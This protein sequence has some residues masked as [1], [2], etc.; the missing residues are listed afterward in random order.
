MDGLHDLGG[1]EGFGPVVKK[2]QP[3]TDDWEIRVNALMGHLLKRHVFNMDEYRHAIERMEPRQYVGA[4]Y[5]E[6]VFTAVATLS[7]EKGLITREE[8]DA[9]LGE[10]VPL[11]RPSQSGRTCEGPLPELAI[12]DR[13]T[14]KP[15][16][17]PGH[18][19]LPAYIRGKTG[20][21][22]GVSPAYPFPDAA[23]HG[24]ESPRQRT[25]D[26]RF[27]SSDLWPGGCEEADV[28]VGVF[29]A[30]LSKCE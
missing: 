13:V 4:S 7:V 10:R 18:I 24:L 27:R 6:R 30:Y 22:V 1:R 3:F 21:V 28:H 9:A 12:G 5:F 25:F 26:V 23:A 29:H 8:L 2:T 16:F 19:R 14:V 11:S 17:V 20:T 15:E